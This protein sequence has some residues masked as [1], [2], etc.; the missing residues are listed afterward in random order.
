[1]TT[2]APSVFLAGVGG[3]YNYGCEAIVRGT[4]HLL[5]EKWPGCRIGYASPQPEMDAAILSD[6]KDIKI[7]QSNQRWTWNRVLRGIARRV[8]IGTGSQVP[9]KRR[10]GDGWDVTLSI[11]GDNY[12]LS[13]ELSALPFFTQQLVNWGERRVTRGNLHVL[14]G[15]SIGPFDSSPTA[16][17]AMQEHLPR[18]SLLTVREQDSL[19]YVRTMGCQSNAVFAADPAF[20]MP[21]GD[22]VV[23]SAGEPIIGVSLSELSLRHVW[24]GDRTRTEAS[25]I[26][27]VDFLQRLVREG[28]QVRLIP[29]VESHCPGNN[30]YVFLS[31][32]ARRANNKGISVVGPQLGA[33]RTKAIIAGCDVVVA[34]R[35]H[36]AVAA[37]SSEVP[38]ILLGYSVKAR[39]MGR[40]VYGNS[41]M[42]IPIEAITAAS[43]TELVQGMLVR[44]RE[45]SDILRSARRRAELDAR[46][47]VEAVAKLLSRR[48]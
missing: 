14:W 36:C 35:M 34:A 27:F 10:L 3:L 17:A 30:D 19:D 28:C 29:H 7:T 12:A 26:V 41:D 15:A 24:N 44:K 45:I 40:Y 21:P 39:G 23:R 5:R 11:G 13:T 37:I 31:E 18:L 2:T 46:A 42:V 48:G 8:G 22:L 38:T 32:I 47:G 33:P 4:V 9:L 25:C 43:L 1:M 20:M 6:L 16:Y